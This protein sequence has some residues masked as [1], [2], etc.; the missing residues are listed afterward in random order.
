[1]INDHERFGQP[2]VRFPAD[3]FY[4]GPVGTPPFASCWQ[5]Q[6]ISPPSRYPL[7]FRIGRRKLEKERTP[8]LKF[9]LQLELYMCFQSSRER[10]FIFI[11][12]VRSQLQDPESDIAPYGAQWNMTLCSSRSLPTARRIGQYSMPW[13]KLERVLT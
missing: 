11:P 4:P 9:L 1:M 13:C 12:S 3:A 7:L 5:M 8:I 10:C 6:S 2:R